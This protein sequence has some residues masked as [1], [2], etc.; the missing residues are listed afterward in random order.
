MID[1]LKTLDDAISWTRKQDDKIDELRTER[2]RIRKRL[3]TELPHGDKEHIVWLLGAITAIFLG[4][5]IKPVAG[6][7]ISEV[8]RTE[9]QSL[10]D[11]LNIA[12]NQLEGVSL[13]FKR[14][15][16]CLDVH[17]FITEYLEFANR[18]R[19]AIKDLKRDTPDEKGKT[20]E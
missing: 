2:Q 16:N 12:A 1:Q 3:T 6:K 7:R 5:P 10:K 9:N 13:A 8:L 15:G 17:F 4:H 14:H 20:D 11:A 19:Q 18:A